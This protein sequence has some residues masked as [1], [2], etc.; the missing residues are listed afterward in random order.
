MFSVN[1]NR[2]DL[3]IADVYINSIPVKMEVASLLIINTATYQSIAQQ[4]GTSPLE[5]TSAT[6]STYTGQAAIELADHY[7]NTQ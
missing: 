7:E 6:L 5:K 1:S 4:A 3:I 2:V